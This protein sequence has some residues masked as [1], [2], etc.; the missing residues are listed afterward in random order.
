MYKQGR[1]MKFGCKHGDAKY[2]PVQN[3]KDFKDTNGNTNESEEVVF[4][5]S[6]YVF[7]VIT[8]FR[9]LT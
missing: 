5:G 9:V 2:T 1:R 8:S 6:M 3:M 7:E 4:H